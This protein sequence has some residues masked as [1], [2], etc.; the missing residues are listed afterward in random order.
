MN[1]ENCPFCNTQIIKSSFYE[2]AGFRAIYNIAPVLPGHTLVI[3][4]KH[5]RSIFELSEE[6][7]YNMMSFSRK[8]IRVLQKAFHAKSFDWT[9]QEGEEAGQ[10]IEHLHLHIVPRTE[11]DLPSPG[12]WY[13]ELKRNANEYIDSAKRQKLSGEEMGKIVMKLKSVVKGT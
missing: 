11:G 4:V 5:V 12:D 8:V 2:E 6:E 10:T 13:P 7:F 9:I 3:P 1:S